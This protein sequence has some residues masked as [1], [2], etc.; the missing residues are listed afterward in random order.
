[1]TQFLSYSTKLFFKN[2]FEKTYLITPCERILLFFTSRT[3]FFNRLPLLKISSE[4][5]YSESQKFKSKF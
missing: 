2:G 4:E 5:G 3:V 1:M